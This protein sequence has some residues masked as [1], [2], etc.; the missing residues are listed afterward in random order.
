MGSLYLRSIIRTIWYQAKNCKNEYFVVGLS[1]TFAFLNKGN[2]APTI[3][4]PEIAFGSR[5]IT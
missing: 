1:M 3:Y 5:D 4:M 2:F